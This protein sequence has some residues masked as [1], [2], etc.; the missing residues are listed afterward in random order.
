MQNEKVIKILA[1]SE[2]LSVKFLKTCGNFVYIYISIHTRWAPNRVLA[3]MKR[4][5]QGPGKHVT[6]LAGCGHACNAPGRLRA[7]MKRTWQAARKRGT[8][9]AG[10]WREKF[11]LT[12][13]PECASSHPRTSAYGWEVALHRRPWRTPEKFGTKIVITFFVGQLRT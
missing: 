12:A 10:C 11:M 13:F 3:H 9:R 1:N 2:K 7:C 8:H 6:H 5:W 4:T